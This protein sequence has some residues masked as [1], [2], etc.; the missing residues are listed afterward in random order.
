MSQNTPTRTRTSIP[1]P[2]LIFVLGFIVVF[3]VVFCTLL[4]NFGR[5]VV[6]QNSNKAQVEIVVVDTDT[7]NSC[8]RNSTLCSPDFVVIADVVEENGST[9]RETFGF[10]GSSRDQLQIYQEM[11]KGERFVVTTYGDEDMVRLIDDIVEQVPG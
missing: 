5:A 1:T 9:H 2:V 11:D 7:I 6:N 3:I 4:F 10:R 8:S